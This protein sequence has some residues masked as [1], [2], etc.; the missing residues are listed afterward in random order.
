MSNQQLSDYFD[1]FVIKRL[2]AVEVDPLASNQHEFNGVKALKNLLGAE[3]VDF[4]ARFV[5][6]SEEEGEPI[7]KII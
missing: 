4:D 3:K 1:G 7:P 5:Y 6:L 2:S